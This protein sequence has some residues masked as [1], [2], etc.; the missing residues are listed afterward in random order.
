M[1]TTTIE[2]RDAQLRWSE[3][4]GLVLNGN[5]VLVTQAQTP[6]IRMVPVAPVLAPEKNYTKQ[7]IPGLH[8]GMGW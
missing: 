1:T 8:A 5:E 3:L 4:L 6:I 2:L 7:R